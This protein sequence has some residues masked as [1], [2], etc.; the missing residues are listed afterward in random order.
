MKRCD[1][2][3]NAAAGGPEQLGTTADSSDPAAQH[4]HH[5]GEHGITGGVCAAAAE[6]EGAQSDT[7]TLRLMDP[8]APDR[9]VAEL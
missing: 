4:G 8:C 2:V 7:V 9:T 1:S 3:V 5:A 6:H